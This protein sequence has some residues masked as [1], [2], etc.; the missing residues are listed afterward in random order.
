MNGHGP[1]AGHMDR[2]IHFSSIVVRALPE[3]VGAVG[4]LVRD[5]R[6][7]SVELSDE[8]GRMVVLLETPS[9]YEVTE[10][11]DILSRHP[12]VL[13]AA[14]VYHQIEKA[15]RADAPVDAGVQPEA[16]VLP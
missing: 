6:G 14:L 13:S 10:A 2:D 8:A 9:L 16:E 1:E 15:G 7:A 11:V 3:T 12:G 4:D 5:I